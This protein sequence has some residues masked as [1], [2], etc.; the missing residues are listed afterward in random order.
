MYLNFNNCF[1][2]GFQVRYKL[3]LYKSGVNN[4][5]LLLKD[6][7]SFKCKQSKV[8]KQ[9]VTS[10]RAPKHFKVGRHHVHT[11]SRLL[12]LTYTNNAIACSSVF[13]TPSS[14]KVFTNNLHYLA[15]QNPV[16]KLHSIT[17]TSIYRFEFF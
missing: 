2:K 9:L 13:R 3:F 7:S 5:R 17:T 16:N 15:P 1:F 8:K 6:L 4:T 11:A 14:L 10:L 12:T